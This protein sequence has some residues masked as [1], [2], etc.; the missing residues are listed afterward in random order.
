MTRQLRNRLISL[1]QDQERDSIV[2]GDETCTNAD[3]MRVLLSNKDDLATL[4]NE[5]KAMQFD[6]ANIKTEQAELSTQVQEIGTRLSDCE[7]EVLTDPDSIKSK[8]KLT[9]EAL[10]RTQ[11]SALKTEYNSMQYNIIVYN[12]HEK[13]TQQQKREDQS[14]SIDRAYFVLEEVLGIE[15]ARTTI[16]LSTAHR[17]P[18]TV[19]GARRPLIFKLANL[20]DKEI[21]WSNIKNVKVYNNDVIDSEKI[22]VQMV[23]L[24]AKLA[25]D[26][27]SLLTDFMKARDAKKGPKWRFL[28]KSG[29][30]CYQID[31][32]YYKPTVDYFLHV[33]ESNKD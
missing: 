17:L 14:D 21:L 27:Q 9:Q 11:I 29:T 7:R 24:P 4:K 18:T 22:H 19:L 1:N 10:R 26:K 23:Q 28:K 32:T 13:I 33:F 20:S 3:L 6:I 8:L 25:H 30:Y 12:M 15:N 16:K 31:E 5:M 2:M